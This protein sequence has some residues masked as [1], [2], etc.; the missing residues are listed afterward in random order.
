MTAAKVL[1]DW[2]ALIERHLLHLR[3]MRQ[4]LIPIALAPAM[5]TLVFG[6]L[7][8]SVVVVTGGSYREYIMAGIVIQLMT[9]AMPA[10][11]IGIIEDLRTGLMDRFRSLPMSGAAVLVGRSFGDMT[12]RAVCCVPMALVGVAIGWRVH[13]GV[14]GL[15]AGFAVL[16]L[17]GFALAWLGALFGLLSGN[18]ETAAGVPGLLLLPMTFL[19]NAF[20]PLNRLPGW[21]RTIAEWNPLSPVVT[22][23]RELW[24]NPNLDTVEGFP[25]RHPLLMTAIWWVAIMAVAVPLS[26]RRFR[27]AR[28]S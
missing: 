18:P 6:V 3:R 8:A 21:L 20:V 15:L 27:T 13:R 12:T 22:S 4:R 9:S 19:S 11:A 16:L 26:V 7:F 17:F 5:F 1:R 23:A 2:L 25:L 24:G 28:I 14:L 10:A